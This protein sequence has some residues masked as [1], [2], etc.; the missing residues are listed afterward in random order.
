MPG[1][2][3]FDRTHH[4]QSR[5]DSSST[6][7]GSLAAARRFGALL[8]ALNWL[9]S[10]CFNCGSC[11]PFKIPTVLVSP[12]VFI[13]VL[14]N[15]EIQSRPTDGE[16]NAQKRALVKTTNNQT[17]RCLFSTFFLRSKHRST[18]SNHEIPEIVEREKKL[19]SNI[20]SV[21]PMKHNQEKIAA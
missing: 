21:D 3:V 10:I 8:F 11:D 19:L 15:G 12:F 18:H 16:K 5:A 17:K 14:D 6:S 2:P 1:L 13:P 4:V 9:P 20:E 7:S